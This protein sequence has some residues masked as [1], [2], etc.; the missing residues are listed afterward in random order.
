MCVYDAGQMVGTMFNTEA[1]SV[2]ASKHH[3]LQQEAAARNLHRASSQS[4]RTL[5]GQD[6]AR[7]MAQSARDSARKLQTLS[8]QV[9]LIQEAFVS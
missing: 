7:N 4:M 3:R 8:S 2:L 1:A 6:D 9:Q 5:T